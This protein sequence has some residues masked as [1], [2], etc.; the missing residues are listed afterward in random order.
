MTDAIM[1]SE[2][3]RIDANQIVVTGDS[4]DKTEAD[5]GMNKII[6]EEILAVMGGH[7][8]I[9]KEKTVEDNIEIATEINVMGEGEIGTGLEKGNFLETLIVLETIEYKQQ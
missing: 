2:A 7:I 9:L 5:P 3:I 1:I 8:K 6:G 4:I